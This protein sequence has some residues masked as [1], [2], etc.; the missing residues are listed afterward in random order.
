M[1]LT[2]FFFMYT[3]GPET[4]ARVW[5]NDVPVLRYGL[6]E[7]ETRNHTSPAIHLMQPGENTFAIEIDVAPA[8][9]QVSF[10]LSVNWDHDRPVMLF[11]WRAETDHLDK[12]KRS[13]F[14]Y[15]TSFSPLGDLF[16]PVHLGA[17]P[18][19]FPCEGNGALHDAVRSF[20]DAIER[21]DLD[22]YMQQLDLK[23]SEMERAYPGWGW[24]DRGEVRNDIKELF[25]HDL[26][27]RPLDLARIHFER[28]VDGKVACARH[29]DGGHVVEAYCKDDP[30]LCLTADVVMTYNDSRWR[31][32]R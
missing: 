19:D 10:E 17:Q 28:R 14:R 1:D 30:T 5:M 3:Q 20:H 11:E 29:L 24:I 22:G 6:I 26:A 31:V 27:V 15:E 9:S 7:D 4:S 12:D 2:P 13:P 23:I 16:S 25:S 18:Q 8:W 21:R 32:F